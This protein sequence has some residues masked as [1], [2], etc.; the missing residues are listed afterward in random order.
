MVSTLLPA[1]RVLPSAVDA[2]LAADA[3]ELRLV[4]RAVVASILR[5]RIEHAD[6]EDCTN[7]ALRRAFVDNLL[8]AAGLPSPQPSPQ[9]GEGASPLSLAGRGRGEGAAGVCRGA[10]SAESV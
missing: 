5:E 8:Y 9:Q 1:T 6:V 2:A 3:S 7:E 10:C 4:V